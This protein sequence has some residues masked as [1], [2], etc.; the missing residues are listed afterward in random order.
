MPAFTPAQPFP[1]PPFLE[2][3]PLQW[4]LIES[5]TVP[6][7]MQAA[8]TKTNLKYQAINQYQTQVA[9]AGN[10]IFAFVKQN[11]FFW[12]KDFGAN[13]AFNATVS[14]SSEDLSTGQL[15]IKAADGVVD[16]DPGVSKT[17]WASLIT[18]PPPFIAWINLRWSAPVTVS[19]LILYDRRDQG[20]NVIAGTLRL[21]DGTSIPVG[22]LLNNGAGVTVTCPPRVVTSLEFDIQ[23]ANG[24]HIGLAEIEVYATPFR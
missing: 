7:Q 4:N 2:T 18:L 23:Q 15:G 17:E 3:T 22:P 1:K 11:E 21:S 5:I 6:V 14:V 20:E 13:L 12:L 8:G 16:G 19:Q 24:F 10:W 9:L